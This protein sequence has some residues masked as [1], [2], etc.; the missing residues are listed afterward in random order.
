M[1]IMATFITRAALDG[2]LGLSAGV[3]IGRGAVRSAVIQETTEEMKD[4][5]GDKCNNY[6]NHEAAMTEMWQHV[7]DSL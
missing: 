4:L 2:G 1:A 3:R 6:V 5:Y 7:L